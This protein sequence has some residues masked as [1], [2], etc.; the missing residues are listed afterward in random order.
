MLY[1]K[2]KEARNI[3]P[4]VALTSSW[5]AAGVVPLVAVGAVG[6]VA[7]ERFR[8]ASCFGSGSSRLLF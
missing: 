4:W 3:K 1:L 2:H 8:R 7:I 5:E 6:A